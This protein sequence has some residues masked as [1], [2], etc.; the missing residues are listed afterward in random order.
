MKKIVLL[1]FLSIFI[2]LFSVVPKAHAIGTCATSFYVSVGGNTEIDCH[3][4]CWVVHNNTC[5]LEIFVPTKTQ[6]EWED[7]IADRPA[8][9]S[10]A[11]CCTANGV[12]CGGAG[13]CCSSQCWDG[14]C[15][16]TNCGGS[17]C[18]ACDLVG[19]VGVCS[20]VPNGED[21]DDECPSYYK[22][23]L[24]NCNGGGN[25][26]AAAAGKGSCPE[27]EECD[28]S[29]Y[30]CQ[31]V[32][33]GT[34]PYGDCG[35]MGCSSRA[36]G[37]SGN[38]C[39][40]YGS[41]TSMDGDC[42]GGSCVDSCSNACQGTG[43]AIATCGS[44]E[45]KKSCSSCA[46]GLGASDVCYLNTASGLCGAGKYCDGSGTCQSEKANGA[47]CSGSYQC[48]SGICYTDSDNDG[49]A[50]SGSDTCRASGSS[51]SDCDDS[52]SSYWVNRSCYTDSDSDGAY[53]TSTRTA[54]CGA[55]CGSCNVSTNGSAGNDCCDTDAN[56]KVGQT[57][58]FSSSRSG[59][60]GYDYD[61]NG[62]EWKNTS[63]CGE[64]TL[65][66]SGS[67]CSDTTCGAGL[68]STISWNCQSF[69]SVS[70]GQTFSQQRC[71]GTWYDY[72]SCGANSV[73][74]GPWGAG[75]MNKCSAGVGSGT[76]GVGL[77]GD[78]TSCTCR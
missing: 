66:N 17:L 3:S 57:S 68:S 65:C 46:S 2:S 40:P 30:R 42:D 78:S 19:T 34:D 18:A 14:V 7:F 22:C 53:S 20:V 60:G 27:C 33:N 6:A 77:S 4:T 55:S 56:A 52:S 37:W 50:G 71:K 54:C 15:C 12:A 26:Q 59:C 76:T 64:C 29:Y 35:S 39:I 23:A 69:A 10:L 41:A 70:C 31:S 36:V 62:S 48:I 32:D 8:C 24:A 63:T 45:C 44:S 61:C 51:G 1:I 67:A 16:N 9:T 72:G 58:Y 47:S 11:S 73:N 5:P 75:T 74:I 25:C 13:E 43:A 28:G 49:Y 21:P 38:S